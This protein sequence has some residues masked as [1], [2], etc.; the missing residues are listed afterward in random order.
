MHIMRAEVPGPSVG[1]LSSKIRTTAKILYSIYLIMTL[2]EIIL[3]VCG[4]MPLFDSLIHSFGSAG[5]GG[6]S[7]KSLSVG[8]YNNAY[9]EIVIGVFM[10]LFGI[11]FNPVSYTHLISSSA[12]L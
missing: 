3:L 5:T 8:A 10:F 11:N 7:N 4:G 6:F 12:T 9:F 2:S 1:K